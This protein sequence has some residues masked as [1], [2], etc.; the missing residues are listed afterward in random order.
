MRSKFKRTWRRTWRERVEDAFSLALEKAQEKFFFLLAVAIL[1]AFI[2]AVWAAPKCR[3]VEETVEK[4]GRRYGTWIA[5]LGRVGFAAQIAAILT[6][7]GLFPFWWGVGV[8]SAV[9]FVCAVPFFIMWGKIL[10]AG[11]PIN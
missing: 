11:Q 1:F 10:S 7:F 5:W 6:L 8:T 2:M 4:Y 3:P 9:Y